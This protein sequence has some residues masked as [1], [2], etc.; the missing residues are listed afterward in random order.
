MLALIGDP[1]RWDVLP[2][3]TRDWLAHQADV[4]ALPQP[5][6]LLSESFRYDGR[7][8]FALYGFAGATRCRRW[9]C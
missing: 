9:A 1:A 6:T 4:S 7:W 2:G 3:N 5:G 8:H